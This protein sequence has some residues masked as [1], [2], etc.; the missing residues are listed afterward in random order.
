MTE[1]IDRAVHEG[2]EADDASTVERRQFMRQVGAG[3][4]VAGG[5]WAAPSILRTSVAFAAGSGDDELE[6]PDPEPPVDL[7]GDIVWTPTANNPGPSGT[8]HLVPFPKASTNPAVQLTSVVS[9]LVGP[10][11]PSI[12]NPQ[13]A[14]GTSTSFHF[15]N[16]GANARP[17]QGQ[18][19]ITS[20]SPVG[21]VLVQHNPDGGNTSVGSIANYQQVTFTFNTVIRN[22]RFTIHDLSG[23][24]VD[25]NNQETDYILT[26]AELAPNGYLLSGKYRDAVGFNR[27]I[28]V[29][30]GVL[31]DASNTANL[32]GTGTF[33]NP[34]RRSTAN[35]TWPGTG[36][37]HMNVRVT[38]PGPLSSFTMRYATVGGRGTQWIS[39]SEHDVRPLLTR[40]PASLD[41]VLRRPHHHLT[42][43]VDDELLVLDPVAGALHT[44]S[45]QRGARVRRGRRIVDRDDRDACE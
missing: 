3:A 22:L 38:M 34:L 9:T 28:T 29:T 10:N 23:S 39:I 15:R 6:P 37:N 18:G 5:A 1:R 20:G 35:S 17:F 41:D 14:T 25:G 7:C 16:L 42:A 11:P 19:S 21:L 26:P 2:P 33:S 43:S 40:V 32:A 45:P 36:T 13:L 12:I 31:G 8:V 27:A 24:T 44:L 4:V 30:P